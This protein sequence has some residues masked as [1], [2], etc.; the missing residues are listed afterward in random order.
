[1]AAFSWVDTK[2]VRSP[3]SRAYAILNDTEQAVSDNVLM[4]MRSYDISPIVW[5]AR[6][7]VREELAA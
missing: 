5:S 2:E 3:N 4:A 7:D 1:M 6:D